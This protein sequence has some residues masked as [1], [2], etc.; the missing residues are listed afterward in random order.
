MKL[1]PTIIVIF[2]IIEAFYCGSINLTPFDDAQYGN[3]F[4]D[5]NNILTV[6]PDEF[7]PTKKVPEKVAPTENYLDPSFKAVLQ[8]ISDNSHLVSRESKDE[9]RFMS[10]NQDYQKNIDETVNHEMD[11]IARESR[12]EGIRNKNQEMAAELYMPQMG[13]GSTNNFLKTPRFLEKNQGQ[14]NNGNGNGED[15]SQ[16]YDPSEA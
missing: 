5:K 2:L 6:N 13:H 10:K 9:S 15:E 3:Y 7:H 1:F 11:E 4:T 14:D 16:I 8:D 12:E